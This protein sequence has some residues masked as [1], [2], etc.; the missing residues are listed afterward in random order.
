MHSL[1][2]VTSRLSR[3]FQTLVTETHGFK[4]HIFGL[5]EFRYALQ[6]FECLFVTAQPDQGIAHIPVGIIEFF[7]YGNGVLI[8]IDGFFIKLQ[9][10]IGRA[11]IEPSQLRVR[12][13]L[14]D[15]HMQTD[16]FFIAAGEVSPK[17]HFI[18]SFFIGRLRDQYLANAFK[19]PLIFFV[20]VKHIRHL[21][22]QFNAFLPLK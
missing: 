10:L 17:T 3:L 13:I 19:Y 8:G 20:I 18:Q 7:L 22:E 1:S 16:A 4:D 14:Q 6:C 9:A 21:E 11:Q 12:M 15:F 5:G 2:V